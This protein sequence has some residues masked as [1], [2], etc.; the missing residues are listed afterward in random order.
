[1][2]SLILLA[3]ILTR[4]EAGAIKT[5][6]TMTRNPVNREIRAG[7]RATQNGIDC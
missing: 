3:P 6:D 4:T 2:S 5:I 7:S 1:M